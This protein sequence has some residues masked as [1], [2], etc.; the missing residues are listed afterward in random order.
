MLKSKEFFKNIQWRKKKKAFG[1]EIK[2]GKKNQCS[3]GSIF[4]RI[5]TAN[6]ISDC[7]NGEKDLKPKNYM[8]I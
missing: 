3:T 4:K 2:S 8:K 6:S 1:K 7:F 5:L